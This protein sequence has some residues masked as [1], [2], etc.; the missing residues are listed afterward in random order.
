[1]WLPKQIHVIPKPKAWWAVTSAWSKRD[2]LHTDTKISATEKAKIIAG[3]QSA[4][5][6]IHNKDG[7]IRSTNSYGSD[8]FPPRDRK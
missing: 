3:N 4:E 8:P 7:K 5:L 1:M 6:R 2:I